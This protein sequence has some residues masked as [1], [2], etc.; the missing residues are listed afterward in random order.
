MILIISGTNRQG[1]NTLKVAK[2]YHKVLTDRGENVQL[3][4]LDEMKSLH[5]DEHFV[6]LETE[7]LIPAQK[8]IILSPEYNGSFPGILKLMMDLSDLKAVWNG[9]KV[10]LVGIANGRAGNARGLDILT[11]MLHYMKV[12]VLPNKLPIS[13]VNTLLNEEGNVKDE[14][15]I[16]AIDFQIED[17]LQF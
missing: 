9:K 12:H 7:Y 15:T 17:F 13:V 16:K 10:A 3:L 4:S 14:N 2:H 8:F 1:S 6:K 5:K 11:N